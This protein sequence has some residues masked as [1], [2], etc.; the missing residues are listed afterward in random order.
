VLLLA[1]EGSVLAQ[2]ML[3]ISLTD[4]SPITVAVDGRYFNKRGESV[5]VG[6]LPMGRHYLKIFVVNQNA[7][8]ENVQRVVFEGK[9][10][11]YR[12]QLTLFTCDPYNNT[13]TVSEQDMDA[14]GTAQ[15]DQQRFNNRNL[16]N[17]DQRPK[18][19]NVYGEREEKQPAQPQEDPQPQY[20]RGN[21]LPEGMPVA[22]PEEPEE[23]AK[24]AT[25]S[26]KDSKSSKLDKVKKKVAGKKTDTDILN[27]V[28][29]ELKSEQLTTAQ[30]CTVMGWFNFESSKSEFAQW[31]YTHTSDKKNF[32]KVKDKLTYKQ[33]KDEIDKTIK[34][35]K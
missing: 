17:Y 16:N 25:K 19:D 32:E 27:T 8:G 26:A 31:A 28:K 33:Y 9:V 15:A 20:E 1:A 10:K 14:Y 4:R 6:D 11:T 24:K 18:D 23:P 35:K 22:S 5:T 21:Q 30:V 12:G 13:T 3:K 34:N 7:R 29:E 2:S